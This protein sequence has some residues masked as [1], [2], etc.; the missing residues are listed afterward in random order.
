MDTANTLS[1][2]DLLRSVANGDEK[3][4]RQLVDTYWK[5]VYNNT[6]ALTKDTVKAQEITQDIFLKIWQKRD[7]LVEVNSFMHFVYV[8]GRNQ[9]ISEMRKKLSDTVS[10]DSAQDILENRNLPDMELQYKETW[11]MILEAI[12]TMPARQQEV[13]KLSRI[14]GLSNKEIAEKLGL[15]IAAVKWHIV[16]GLNTLRGYLAIHAGENLLVIFIISEI[17]LHTAL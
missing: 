10:T 17:L 16:A 7:R 15:S 3:A 12:N 2:S 1:E 13:F 6:L 11:Q 4:F 14:E 9:V 5:R 8:V